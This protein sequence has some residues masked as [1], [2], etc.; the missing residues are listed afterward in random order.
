MLVGR[1]LQPQYETIEAGSLT[2]EVKITSIEQKMVMLLWCA[3]QWESDVGL[4]SAT[5]PLLFEV[6]SKQHIMGVLKVF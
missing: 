6:I 2:H 5:L 4:Y 1:E 3:K